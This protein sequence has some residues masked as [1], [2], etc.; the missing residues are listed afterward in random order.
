MKA[1]HAFAY[2]GISFL[3]SACAGLKL[4]S[5]PNDDADKASTGFRYYDSAPFL[6][7]HTDNK[8]GLTSQVLYLPDL[9]RKRA[10]AP[11]NYLASNKTTLTFDKGK[12]QQ[13]KSVV[14]ETIVP[15]AVI[16]GLEKIATAAV[17]AAANAA[18]A[19]DTIPPPMLFRIVKV[20]GKWGLSG[21]Q[22]LDPI[23][24]ET[25]IRFAAP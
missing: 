4:E 20:Q 3:L 16:S 1:R 6:L 15:A 11:Y 5:I 24:N 10:A 22:A 13:S 23:G 12:L 21:G 7:V 19:G 9:T 8:G 18:N 14:D 2:A 17:K 25:R